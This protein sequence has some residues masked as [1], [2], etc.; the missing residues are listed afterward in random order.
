MDPSALAGVDD[1]VTEVPVVD[2]ATTHTDGIGALFFAT[3]D[4]PL[5]RTM[6][7]SQGD[8]RAV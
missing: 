5:S 3:G 8:R 1:D 7:A 4:A 6:N 2:V